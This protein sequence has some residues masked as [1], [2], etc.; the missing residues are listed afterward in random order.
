MVRREAFEAAEAR[1]AGL[2]A[3][4]PI[5]FAARDTEGLERARPADLEPIQISRSGLG[6]HFPRLDADLHLPALLEGVF[7]SRR[8]LLARAEEPVAEQPR[9]NAPGGGD[10]DR[11]A[12]IT[13]AYT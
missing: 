2:M 3:A 11:L 12:A 4:G 6:L 8:R 10:L 5:A 9:R 1:A 13:N 7:G